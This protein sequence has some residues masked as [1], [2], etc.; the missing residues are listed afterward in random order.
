MMA[1]V[2]IEAASFGGIA[3]SWAYFTLKAIKICKR[4]VFPPKIPHRCRC[5]YCSNLLT[6]DFLSERCGINRYFY[7]CNH[8]AEK[9]YVCENCQERFLDYE[10]ELEKDMVLSRFCRCKT[11]ED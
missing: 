4:I 10:E 3:Y 9:E 1:E 8:C 6:S 2:I 11:I 5:E 7:V